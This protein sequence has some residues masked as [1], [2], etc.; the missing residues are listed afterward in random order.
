MPPTRSP[1][2][3]PVPTPIQAESGFAASIIRNVPSTAVQSGSHT[4]QKQN[5]LITGVTNNGGGSYKITFSPG[6]YMPN[7]SSGNNAQMLG[8]K[9]LPGVTA[10]Q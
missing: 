6:L 4:F 5:V 9:L 8:S 3:P 1:T 10:R 2:V 7:W